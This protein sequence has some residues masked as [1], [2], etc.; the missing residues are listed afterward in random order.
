M[1]RAARPRRRAGCCVAVVAAPAAGAALPRRRDGVPARRR[2]PRSA[3]RRR[4]WSCSRCCSPACPCA[5]CV[6]RGWDELAAGL[7][8]GHRGAAGDHACPTAAPTSG[9]A[10]RHR[11]R[12]RAARG[13]RGAARRSGR[14]AARTPRRRA[15][16]RSRSASLYAVPVVERDADRA[17]PRRRAV[18]AAARRAS[19]GSSACAAARSAAAAASL[20]GWRSLAALAVAPRARR[21]QRPWID[22][23]Q[24]RR[25]TSQP[26]AR[27]DLRL[28]PQLRRRWTGRATGARSCGSRPPRRRYWKAASLDDFDGVRWRQ[29]AARDPSRPDTEI[30]RR[31]PTGSQTIR[32]EVRGHAQPRSSSARARPSGVRAARGRR[33]R[34]STPGHLRD[35]RGRCA[36]ATPTARAST[37][38]QPDA[39]PAARRRARLP[40]LR[41]PTDARACRVPVAARRVRDAASVRLRRPSGASSP[42][43]GALT[44]PPTARRS[45]ARTATAR[46]R[47]AA[48]RYAPRLA[49]AQRLR[50]ASATPYDFVRRVAG[51]S[52]ARRD[53]HR[54]AAARARCRST[55][56]S[57][58]TGRATASS[59]PAPWRCC[60]AWAASRRGSR[61]ASRPAARRARRQRV[62][63]PRPRRPL[64]GRGLLPAA[65]AG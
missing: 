28:G 44:V 58:A 23:E 42:E 22:Y 1:G 19:V 43:L 36:A 29:G 7:G 39:R 55:R 21:A 31:T 15:R 56:S 52:A 2:R 34:R 14:G 37:C 32:V 4:R 9:C 57:S 8:A 16:P 17:V 30:A 27:V 18:R 48:R 47:C 38:P 20:V 10:S 33:S 40:G 5:C 11:R 41:A 61:R 12:R 46:G 13:A 65:S 50:A 24:T 25:A 60:C 64:V 6:P 53:L 63:R 49:L 59:S 35:V 54:D 51:A 45:G 3:R 62:R 26:R